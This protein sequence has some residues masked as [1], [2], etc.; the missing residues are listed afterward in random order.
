M[1]HLLFENDYII[2]CR[3]C[4]EDF[5]GIKMVL[6]LFEDVTGQK[7][8][9]DKSFFCFVPIPLTILRSSARIFWEWSWL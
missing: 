6:H 3:A 8:N 2:F 4:N 5:L 1:F 7:I 9:F